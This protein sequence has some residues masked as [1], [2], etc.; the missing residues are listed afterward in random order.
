MKYVT[1]LTS[2]DKELVAS[3]L[4]DFFPDEIFDIHV[5]PFNCQH[6][7][8][9]SWPFLDD[10][11]ILDCNKH[12]HEIKRY[13]PLKMVHGLYFGLPHRTANRLVMNQWVSDEVRTNGTKLSRTLLV[14]SPLD[15]KK[16]LERSLKSG[17]FCGIKPY[18]C[19]AARTDT[20]NASVSEFV[21]EW[22]WELLNETQGI[23]MLHIVRYGAIADTDN[24]RELRRLCRAYP[25]VRLILA[26]V[27]RSFNYRNARK[28]LEVIA[29]LDNVVVDTSAI[30]EKESFESALKTLGSSRVLWGSDF[31]ISE[32]RGRCVTTGNS[33]FWLHPESI[34]ENLRP[35]TD[36]EM[37]LVGIESLL[38][39]KEACEDVGLSKTDIKKIFLENALRV[40]QPHLPATLGKD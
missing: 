19:Y 25:G 2:Q 34:R 26:H 23:L 15:D 24:Q 16:E 6:F 33:F 30:C 12:Q 29:D 8:K 27:A 37:T 20:M 13:M 38:A 7:G 22:M 10:V 31:P 3:E 5:H 39:L 36:R 28:G 32:M 4:V 14:T 21:P 18:H 1:K 40:L 35:A 11:G 17:N 9:G